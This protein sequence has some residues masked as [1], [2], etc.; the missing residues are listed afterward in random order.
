[1]D[2][3]AYD[4]K[5]IK[6]ENAKVI[7]VQKPSELPL[8]ASFQLDADKLKH[9]NKIMIVAHPDDETLWGGNHLLTDK[10]LVVCITNGDN[11]IR[12]KEFFNAMKMSG[13]YG[14][15]LKYPDNPKKVKSNW[16]K[17]KSEIR[18][19]IHYLLQYKKWNQIVTHNPEGEYGHIHHKFTSMMVTNECE[20]QKLTNRLE[21]F[22][23]YRSADFLLTHPTKKS[24][25]DAQVQEKETIMTECY[26]SQIHAHQIFDHMMP[27]EK[28]IPYKDWYFG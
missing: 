27:Y 1:M 16:K 21:Y 18:E 24:L 28:F 26:P 15:M 5:L 3:K 12:E 23:K 13:S 22:A 8:S 9:I 6:H 7:Q 19:D 14:V 10:Y 25:T 11:L 17:V 2:L 4:A 20:K